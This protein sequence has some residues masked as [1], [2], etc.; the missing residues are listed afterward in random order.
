MLGRKEAH[1]Q[2]TVSRKFVEVTWMDGDALCIQEFNRQVLVG[3]CRREP[4]HRR[5]AAFYDQPGTGPLRC[6][7]T[8]EF[9]KISP[10]TRDNLFLESVAL[11]EKPGYRQLHRR[12]H[13]D[14]GGCNHLGPRECYPLPFLR[15]AWH[16]PAGLPPPQPTKPP[17]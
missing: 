5:P 16:Q 3:T 11:F 9:C 1:D 2:I 7:L 15:P 13:R 12:V 10:D 6:Q 17:Q 4:Q 8:V 14:I